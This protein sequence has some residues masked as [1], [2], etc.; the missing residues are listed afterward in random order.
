MRRGVKARETRDRSRVWSGGSTK[1]IRPDGNG[2]GDISSSTVPCADE[3]VRVSRLAAS[4]SAKRL[5]A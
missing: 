5:S 4:T 1:I 3:K 2:S